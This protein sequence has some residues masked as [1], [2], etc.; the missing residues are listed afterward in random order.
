MKEKKVH[1]LF[2]TYGK[3]LLIVLYAAIWILSPRLFLF[4]IMEFTLVLQVVYLYCGWLVC[5]EL[6]TAKKNLSIIRTLF[7][8]W[9]QFIK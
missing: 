3:C 2:F 9:F 7:Q 5:W 8:Q 4:L 6:L 1:W